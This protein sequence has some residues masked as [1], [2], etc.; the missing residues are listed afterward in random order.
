MNQLPVTKT[1]ETTWLASFDDE[2]AQEDLNS[3]IWKRRSKEEEQLSSTK[4]GNTL[5][6][7]V[8][9]MYQESRKT[10]CAKDYEKAISAGTNALAAIP[11]VELLD[12]M[13]QKT[14][15]WWQ[16]AII[17][18]NSYYHYMHHYPDTKLYARADKFQNWVVG[19]AGI[20]LFPDP[21]LLSWSLSRLAAFYACR[22]ELF[23]DYDN[24]Y[25]EEGRAR[26]VQAVLKWNNLAIG[27]GPFSGPQSVKTC[28]HETHSLVLL[29]HFHATNVS[30]SLG[31]ALEYSTTVIDS[32]MPEIEAANLT[33]AESRALRLCSH[34]TILS[35]RYQHLRVADE[36]KATST[37]KQAIQFGKKAKEECH[38]NGLIR[39]R[40][41]SSLA[42]W[43]C[44][45]MEH[46]QNLAWGEDG[47]AQLEALGTMETLRP[48]AMIVRSKLYEIQY[49]IFEKRR[50]MI[51]ANE[52]LDLAISNVA[53]VV[54]KLSSDDRRIGQQYKRLADMQKNKF[55]DGYGSGVDR[56]HAKVH[57]KKAINTGH[58]NLSVRLPAA[59]DLAM[60]H[61]RDGD[62]AEAHTFFQQTISLLPLLKQHQ[63]PPQ[64]LRAILRHTSTYAEYAASVALEAGH[65]P[66]VALQSLESS[67]CI[68]SGL[69]MRMKIDLSALYKI[70]SNLAAKYDDLRR[71]L[72][73][74]LRITDTATDAFKGTLD[75]LSTAMAARE[76]EIRELEEFKDFQKPLSAAKMKELANQG[77]IVVINVSE[78]R[79]DAF[80]VTENEIKLINLPCLSYKELKLR[81]DAL[82][83]LGNGGRTG[84]VRFDN[85]SNSTDMDPTEI[86]LWLWDKAVH[87]I[88]D[89]APL[90]ASKRIWWIVTGIASRVPFHA[91]GD[92]T[93]GST[94]N[95]NTRAVSSYISSF[96]ALRFARQQA[97]GA[98]AV[99]PINPLRDTRMLLV[100]VTKNPPGY[101]NLEAK[102]EIKAI[103]EVFSR[104]AS[105]EPKTRL[106][107]VPRPS[108]RFVH[109]EAP[110]PITVLS[111]LPLYSFVHFACHGTN[112]AHDPSESGLVLV[113]DGVAKTLT[114][115]Q[116]ETTPLFEFGEV[117]EIAYLAA[118]STAQIRDNSTLSDEALHLG[119]VLQAL[120]YTHVIATLWRVNDTA[121]GEVARVFYESL[122]TR[123]NGASS[124]S[125]ISKRLDAAGAL[126][127]AIINYQN[128]YR[129]GEYAFAWIPFVHIG[130]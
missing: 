106:G 130:A 47:L 56:D 127:D 68:I 129:G 109:L 12:D 15:Y 83:K 94:D 39:F 100:T 28:I 8:L 52:K 33:A 79:S 10:Q 26:S 107:D 97:A 81:I 108:G 35:T 59:F 13:E 114:V 37:L 66:H 49:Q 51:M 90:Q 119:N 45:L 29:S 7:T 122:L 24:A 20:D 27:V 6:D 92:H 73:K 120:G 116:L 128:I 41:L 95:V 118:C 78:L 58:A 80:I 4:P 72:L 71:L 64:D 18:S 89:S 30:L 96:A 87:E 105:E 125:D 22:H 65:P 123:E 46:T 84:I 25:I 61:L 38:Q 77:P 55:D 63:I 36:D 88:I 115:S 14:A 53:E 57:L 104:F 67:R 70:D 117:G 82:E 121:A 110:S 113:E 112:V 102:H 2:R 21:V 32:Y 43:Y 34:G 17:V 74:E 1:K 86:L 69:S 31:Q 126:H 75:V 85:E 19:L 103:K 40:V 50:D 124:S 11:S 3:F 48:T 101:D 9:S 54:S 23:E 76:E 16:I 44:E 93:Q 5:K 98:A 60:M 99:S 111:S 91:A 62:V 42:A